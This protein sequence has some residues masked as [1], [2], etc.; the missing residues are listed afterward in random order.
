[1]GRWVLVAVGGLVLVLVVAG[2]VVA[3]DARRAQEHLTAAAASVDQLRTQVIAGDEA[4][5]DATLADLQDQTSAAVDASHGPL[6][7]VASRLP[8]VGESVEAVQ[9]VT[10]V[11]DDLAADALPA[12]AQATDVLDPA[13]FAPQDGRIVLTPF[14]DV[15]PQVVRADDA[16]QAGAARLA[17]IDTS[18]LI[19]RLAGPVDDL[20]AMVADVAM[21]TATA[22]RAVQ[23]LPTMLGAY[24][25]R[26][27]LLLAQNNAE[28]RSTGGIPGAWIRITVDDGAIE[29][30]ES[31]SAIAPTA[32]VT[33]LT[34]EEL[35]LFTER[36]ALY[37]QNVNLTPDF[38]RSAELARLMWAGDQGGEQVDG[39]ISI[40]PVALQTVLG[41]T[42]P[43]ILP[44]GEQLDGE[45]AARLLLNEI[46]IREED[47]V[48]QDAYF[49]DAASAVFTAL[50]AGGYDISSM[51]DA[52]AATAREGRILVWS[53]D[54]SE[55]A[56]ISGTVLS[57]EL[58]G[59][60]GTAPVLGVYL[61][62]SSATKMSYYLDYSVDVE[63]LECLSDGT[64]LL[65][66]GVTMTSI[67]TPE[68]AD[69][70][71]YLSG[72]GWLPP[73]SVQT[74]VMVYSPLG[75]WI[76]SVRLDGAESEESGFYSHE[77]MD[78]AVTP[79]T[80]AP[81]ESQTLQLEVLTGL[82]QPDPAILRVTP[83]A[84]S[85]VNAVNDSPC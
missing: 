15:A 33:D 21:T 13:V 62:D 48:A 23:L 67:A 39:V 14:I 68:V 1:V 44:S 31:N 77:G 79:I 74:N 28:L 84:R 10:E 72:G 85:S 73:G 26:T 81:G 37:G 16:V 20:R 30:G 38:P 49:G 29:I 76:E 24:G 6:W 25:E 17:A 53:S 63:R 46:Y 80:L 9:I 32:P 11:V 71:P 45:N 8:V 40:D 65:G 34:D 41:A 3:L 58:A 4:A 61:N 78:V 43:V 70:P 57:G 54:P 22:S 82:G 36:P 55:Q 83:G 75:G 59:E 56:L 69:Y 19:R 60:V 18:R 5:V 66:V 35:A 12:L 47:P 51:I 64:R 27:Y 50:L 7:S 42:G 52:L 2:A